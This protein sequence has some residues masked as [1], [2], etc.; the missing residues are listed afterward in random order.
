[1]EAP[2]P[3]TIRRFGSGSEDARALFLHGGPGLLGYL[4]DLCDAVAPH[5]VGV[6]YEQRGSAD[7]G[8]VVG[9]EDHLRDLNHV[10]VRA[11]PERKPI[12]VGHSWGAMLSVLFA[13]AYPDQVGKLVLIGCG[14]LN[15]DLGREFQDTLDLRFGAQKG[16]YDRLWSTLVAAAEPGRQRELANRYIDAMMPIYQPGWPPGAR[17]SKRRWDFKG[18]FHTMM[19]S[20]E[21]I[22]SGAYE[23]ALSAIKVPVVLI[24]GA[25]DVLSLASL[26]RVFGHHVDAL[27]AHEVAGAGHYPWLG[28]TRAAFLEVLAK[29]LR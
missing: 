25:Q 16:Y 9:V 2:Y 26:S 15:P 3:P 20:D 6:Y 29:E 14:P 11:F 24:H 12:L 23:L 28:P 13:A 8:G 4:E 22:G 5:C 19:E 1:M 10:V 17:L 27:S 7:G 21:R 18:A